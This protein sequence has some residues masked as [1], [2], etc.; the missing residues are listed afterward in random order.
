MKKQKQLD[1]TS[2][3][4]EAPASGL[5][6]REA[7]VSTPG[8]ANKNQRGLQPWK[9]ALCTFKPRS[10]ASQ[11]LTAPL[12]EGADESS[13]GTSAARPWE[14][15]PPVD[16]APRRV[17]TKPRTLAEA[18]PSCLGCIALS[19]FQRTDCIEKHF[20]GTRERIRE[21]ATR[22]PST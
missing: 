21:F 6:R 14:S 15:I 5:S 3:L 22:E 13:P 17:A 11:S 20:R 16:P 18:M 4:I 2:R 7:W 12:P 9:H 19:D 8:K 1:T 10:H